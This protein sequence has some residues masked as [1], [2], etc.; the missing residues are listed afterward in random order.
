MIWFEKMAEVKQ[1]KSVSPVCSMDFRSP[2]ILRTKSILAFEVRDL[3]RGA[4]TSGSLKKIRLKRQH[5]FATCFE[6]IADSL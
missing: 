6:K 4:T 1:G 5:R 3:S 2:R